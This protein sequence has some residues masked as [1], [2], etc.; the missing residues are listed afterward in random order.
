VP[1]GVMGP[2]L[3]REVG[4]LAA[5]AEA[6]RDD[7]GREERS[8]AACRASSGESH[9]AVLQFGA[10]YSNKGP[11]SSQHHGH[12]WAYGELKGEKIARKCVH[13][14]LSI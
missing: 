8:P 4:R 11:D 12:G 6:E 10:H 13:G 3:L 14:T 9:E 5:A 7:R 1:F 2:W